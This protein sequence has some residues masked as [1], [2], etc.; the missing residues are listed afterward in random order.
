MYQPNYGYGQNS[1][2]QQTQ[3][4]QQSFQ[5]PQNVGSPFNQQPAQ[6][7][8]TT[9]T[10]ESR[11]NL[12]SFNTYLSSQPSMNSNNTHT[13]TSRNMTTNNPA[14]VAASAALRGGSPQ[15]LHNKHEKSPFSNPQY[16]AIRQSA[17]NPH[18]PIQGHQSYSNAENYTPQDI[19]TGLTQHNG[20]THYSS[21]NIGR[22]VRNPALTG[23]NELPTLPPLNSSTQSSHQR[24][25]EKWSPSNGNGNDELTRNNSNSNNSSS[26][27]SNS[28]KSN[29]S[30]SRIK[31]RR[32]T[33]NTTNA[34][35]RHLPSKHKH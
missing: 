5:Y 34:K 23:R 16:S 21:I 30:S 24:I 29:S 19:V 27:N 4:Q 33:S 12:P 15:L 25:T 11:G 31:S 7:Y 26:S 32:N 22:I 14:A 35:K 3:Q 13:S 6:H 2:N 18:S 8:S 20:S 9:T 17:N 10:P 1:Q 28:N